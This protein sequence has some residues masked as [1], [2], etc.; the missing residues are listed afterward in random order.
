MH[1]HLRQSGVR[2]KVNEKFFIFKILHSSQM[3]RV[4]FFFNCW[5]FFFIGF[6][7]GPPFSEALFIVMVH[8]APYWLNGYIAFSL[9]LVNYLRLFEKTRFFSVIPIVT[10][11]D[12]SQCF[13]FKA[14]YIPLKKKNDT[15]TQTCTD[16]L[17]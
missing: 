1:S 12:V 2:E 8:E 11:C 16:K 15:H 9:V 6:D 3:V 7:G 4:R 10:S 17:F 14:K 13:A 5:L